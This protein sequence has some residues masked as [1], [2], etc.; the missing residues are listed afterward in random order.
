[1]DWRALISCLIPSS[2]LLS[3]PFNR[4]MAIKCILWDSGHHQNSFKTNFPHMITHAPSE[5]QWRSDVIKPWAGRRS[6]VGQETNAGNCHLHWKSHECYES[7]FTVQ[8]SSGG[9]YYKNINKYQL[10]GALCMRGAMNRSREEGNEQW[11]ERT[12]NTLWLN[13][14]WH[15]I[16]PIYVP[17]TRVSSVILKTNMR[18]N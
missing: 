12:R 17:Q 16:F 7:W 18:C 4:L 11:C 3:A 1:M 14:Q 9:V 8:T 13:H 2:L 6:G 10:C 5:Q 15:L